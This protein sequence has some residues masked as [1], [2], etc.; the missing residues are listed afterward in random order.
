MAQSLFRSIRMKLLDEGKTFKYL[1]YAI[2]EILLII[3]GIFF[4]LQL[5]NWN[6]DRKAQAE[7]DLYIVQL[8]ED[9]RTAIDNVERSK[10]TVENFKVDEEFIPT[11]LELSEYGPEEL[12]TFEKGLTYLGNT[13]QPQV[14][15]GLLGDL[16]NGNTDIIRRNRALAQKALAME[17]NVENLL[18][19]IQRN[20]DRID[21]YSSS[22]NQYRGPG[23]VSRGVPPKYNLEKLKSSDEFIYTTHAIIRSMRNVISFD[24]NITKKLEDFLTVLEEYE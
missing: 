15:V 5:N 23:G 10:T 3:V 17:S 2:G 14:Y 20:S 1:K 22:I 13:S 24:N 8:K 7:F 18:N 11:F 16:M 9:V 4:A 19:N 21:L 6:E 12:A